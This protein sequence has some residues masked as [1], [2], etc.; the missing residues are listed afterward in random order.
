MK[1]LISNAY[2]KSFHSKIFI[3]KCQN[4]VRL[5]NFGVSKHLSVANDSHAL[6]DTESSR[7]ENTFTQITNRNPINIEYI[8]TSEQSNAKPK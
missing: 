7:I 3:E 5:T 2:R 8:L 6:K 4:V 1:I